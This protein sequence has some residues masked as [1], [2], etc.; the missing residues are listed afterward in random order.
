M[1][2]KNRK[3]KDRSKNPYKYVLDIINEEYGIKNKVEKISVK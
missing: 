1:Y 2:V 3:G